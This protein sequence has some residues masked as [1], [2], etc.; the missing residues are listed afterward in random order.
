MFADLTSYFTRSSSSTNPSTRGSG[1]GH[2][3]AEGETPLVNTQEAE[4]NVVPM[5]AEEV[6][7]QEDGDAIYEGI[8]MEFNPDHII[9]DP[10]LR[11]PI[12]QFGPNIR[13]EVSRAFIEKGP[14]QPSGHIFPKG[15]ENRSFQRDWFKKHD[16]LEYSVEKDKAYC[17]FCYLFRNDI[18]DDKFGYEAFTKDGF[19]Q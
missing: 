10:G 6:Q 12:D 7:G 17:F 4:E 1:V 18:D 19:K 15:P 13:Y 8:I 3:A 9:S 11:I 14:T 16:W 2:E 5:P